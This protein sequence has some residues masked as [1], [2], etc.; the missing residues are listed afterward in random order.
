MV[1]QATRQ[2]AALCNAKF[3][4]YFFIGGFVAVA[5]LF[6]H[7]AKAIDPVA[8]DLSLDSDGD[9][10][11]D[12][13]EQV[14]GTDPFDRDSDDDYFTDFEEILWGTNPLGDGIFIPPEP[15]E[16]PETSL[17]DELLADDSLDSDGD[18][19]SDNME[20]MYYTD[21]FNRDTDGDYF[22]DF[23]EMLQGTNPLGDTDDDRD[24]DGLKYSLE[25]KF[26]SNPNAFDTS[27]DGVSDFE[28]VVQGKDPRSRSDE[29]VFDIRIEVD[30]SAQKMYF[31]V[32][33]ENLKQFNVA[34]GKPS[35]PTPSGHFSVFRKAPSLNYYMPAGSAVSREG[36]FI[37]NVEANMQFRS[38]GFFIHER[39]V[40]WRRINNG[41][42][43][44]H[45]CINMRR[46]DAW[47]VYEH[48]PMNTPV[49]VY[50]TTSWYA[51]R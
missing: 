38:G 6:A 20:M 27:G 12:E 22:T 41:T 19:L 7:P 21:P 46:A 44:S 16:E 40:N 9:G 50:G 31:F 24:G 4:V 29:I 34:T 43:S 45:G 35:T 28:R 17:A 37:P 33:D 36:Y 14:Y 49:H 23:E 25:V 47:W 11:T 5:F 3:A 51:R 39:E 2:I 30:K 48:T 32:E 42:A 15:P 10:I 1:K 18:G 13:L 8:V 26:G